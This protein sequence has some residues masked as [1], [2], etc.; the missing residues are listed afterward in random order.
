MALPSRSIYDLGI[1]RTNTSSSS[2]GAGHST[3]L[4]TRHWDASSC[5][6]PTA[7]ENIPAP[8]TVPIPPPHMVQAENSFSLP[9]FPY[10]LF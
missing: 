8:S 6:P 5:P 3:S 1:R 10:R 4:S 9:L 7:P 2:Y